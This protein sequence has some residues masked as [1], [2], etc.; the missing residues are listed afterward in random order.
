MQLYFNCLVELKI[1]DMNVS[2]TLS[3][4]A[5][6]KASETVI[7]FNDEQFTYGKL[8]SGKWDYTRG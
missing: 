6:I 1:S 3:E 2:K 7:I 8:F 4:L 5:V